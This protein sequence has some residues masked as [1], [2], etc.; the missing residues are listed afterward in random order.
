[1]PPPEGSSA[2]IQ[3]IFRAGG[4]NFYVYVSNKPINFSDPTGL[5]PLSSCLGAC[6]KIYYGLTR[7]AGVIL[8]ITAPII[9]K[10]I[11]LG[12]G[13]GATSIASTVLRKL[14]PCRIPG[15]LRAPTIGN[16]AARTP[17][18]GGA[19]ARWLPLLGYGL[20]AVDAYGIQD[21]TRQCERDNWFPPPPCSNGSCPKQ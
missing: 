4:I 7:D 14:L 15:G 10:A 21:C 19:I 8:G 18:L 5:S 17:V 16:L 11:T 20:L 6:L 3:L 12:G 13:T 9:P 2:K 1:M